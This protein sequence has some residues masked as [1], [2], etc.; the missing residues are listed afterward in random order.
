MDS[1]KYNKV[2]GKFN[3]TG[4]AIRII[5]E[6]N[7]LSRQHLSTKL[8]IPTLFITLKCYSISK[9]TRKT[10]FKIYLE[11]FLHLHILL[12][13]L[14]PETFLQSLTYALCINRLFIL[15]RMNFNALV[16][17]TYLFFY[18]FMASL[19]IINIF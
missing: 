17:N 19:V 3:T 6:Q 16:H 4:N 1:R 15:I 8:T 10:S 12:Q 14:H 9:V 5:R 13:V 11:F 18:E 7:N 2:Y